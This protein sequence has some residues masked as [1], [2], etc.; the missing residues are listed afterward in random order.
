[1]PAKLVAEGITYSIIGAAHEVYNALGFGFLEHIYLMALERELLARGHRV[2]REVAVVVRYKGEELGTQRL[3]MLIDE[4]VVVEL[5]STVQLQPMASRQLYN[6]LRCTR[7]EVGLLLHFSPTGVGHFRI[8][9]SNH[10]IVH[11]SQSEGL[12]P[13]SA[14]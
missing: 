12:T 6:Y 8:I 7:V 10:S 4:Q 11:A 5:K 9:S 3:D 14:D 1:M 13:M 2:G